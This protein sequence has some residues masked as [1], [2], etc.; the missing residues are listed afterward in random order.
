MKLSPQS[1]VPSKTQAL[2]LRKDRLYFLTPQSASFLASMTFQE[3]KNL[4]AADQHRYEARHGFR[5]FLK[6]WIRE[7]G[8]RFTVVMRLCAWLRA[9]WWSRYG[10]Y[11]LMLWKHRR[12]QIRY[13]AYI[14]YACQI[15]GGLYLGH[16]CSIVTN[17]RCT[18]GDNCTLGHGVTIGKT[19]DRSKHPGVPMIGDRVYLGCG[20]AILG[21]VRIGDDAVVAPNAVVISDVPAGAVVGGIP[22]RVLSMEGSAGYVSNVAL[23]SGPIREC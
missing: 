17:V 2:P 1:R 19:H 6:Q 10:L 12:M 15:G 9:Q 21:G 20:A 23:Q 18:I 22:A 14:E 3:L 11:H 7:G 4:I 13:G 16:M 5:D 8:F